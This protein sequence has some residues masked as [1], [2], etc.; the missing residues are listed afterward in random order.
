MK[1]Y[2]TFRFSGYSWNH[3][4]G[5]ISLRYCLGDDLRF[6]ET[7]KLPEPVSDERLKARHWQIERLLR[8]LH[9]IGGI[10]YFKTCLPKTILFDEDKALSKFE[11][12][13]WT[14]VYEEGLGEFF[15]RNQIDFRGLIRFPVEKKAQ[16]ETLLPPA[17]PPRGSQPALAERILVPIGGGKDSVVTAELLKQSNIPV[18]L[19]RMNADDKIEN[20]AHALGLPLLNVQRSIDPTLF[21]LNKQGALNGHVPITAYVSILACLL[22]ELYDYSSVA[23]SNE[24]SASEGNVNYLG[25]DINHQWSKSLQ[26][27]K[28]LQRFLLEVV[29]TT[30]SYQSLLRPLSELKIVEMF[31]K[32]PQYFPLTTSCNANWKI[33][34][35]LSKTEM[36][37]ANRSSAERSVGW[38]GHCPKCAFVFACMAA[39]NDK[40]TLE[41]TFG[42]NLFDRDDLL[43]LFRELLGIKN[44]KP[45]ECVGT[46]EETKAAFLL[47]MKRGELKNTAAMKMFEAEVLP[48]IANPDA[49]IEQCLKSEDT[50]V[51]SNMKG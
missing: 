11:H 31:S 12:Q 35:S 42:S 39:F 23:M 51:A 34:P 20:L 13:F 4:A 27:E 43:D 38:C 17:P 16:K 6:E 46:P 49:L 9:L 48:S 2:P 19:F 5:K 47:A 36:W 18:T 41:K 14:T 10:S 50:D 26:F 33:A 1:Q 44:F 3:H 32:Y 30:L 28:L 24:S 29:G 21:Q 37:P 25:K 7:L 22:A 8:A 40:K 15:Y 45:F